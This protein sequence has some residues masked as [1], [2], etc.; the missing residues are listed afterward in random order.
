M[1]IICNLLDVPVSVDMVES[2]NEP[3]GMRNILFG[4]RNI[5]RNFA[6]NFFFL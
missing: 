1:E 2:E 4:E 3:T 5:R 6:N